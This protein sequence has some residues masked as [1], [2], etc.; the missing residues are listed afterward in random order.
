LHPLTIQIRLAQGPPLASALQLYLTERQRLNSGESSEEALVRALQR[1]GAEVIN[2]VLSGLPDGRRSDWVFY[3]Q[4]GS[5]NMDYRSMLLDG[6]V[7]ALISH[8]TS[9][10][11]FFDFMLLMGQVEWVQDQDALDALMP[12]PGRLLRRVGRW[13]R[14]AI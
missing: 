8:W 2:P 14:F 12:P 11:A 13:I 3:L 6:E 4:V 10:Y 1:V 7:A 9:L 5:P